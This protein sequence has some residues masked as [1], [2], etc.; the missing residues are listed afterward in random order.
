MEK[1]GTLDGMTWAHEFL[2]TNEDLDAYRLSIPPENIYV[3]PYK[4]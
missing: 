2:E 1:V 4:L 3:H